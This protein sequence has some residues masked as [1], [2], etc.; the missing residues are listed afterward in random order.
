V[1]T[2]RNNVYAVDASTGTIKLRTKLGPPVPKSQLPGR[3]GNNGESIGIN[4]TPAISD[5]RMYLT[6]FQMNAGRP[7]YYLYAL[8][9][10]TLKEV[11]RREVRTKN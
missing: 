5:G 10:T 1:V 8:D 3:C 11:V 2:E 7:T 9:V 6:S 4:S